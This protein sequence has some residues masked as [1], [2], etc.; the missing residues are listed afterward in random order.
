MTPQIAKSDS[1][2]T[3]DYHIETKVSQKTGKVSPTA[4]IT[5]YA[6]TK[7]R[8]ARIKT[9]QGFWQVF[10]EN[11]LDVSYIRNDL[12]RGLYVKY[13]YKER[14]A[15][16]ETGVLDVQLYWINKKEEEKILKTLRY[17]IKPAA[18]AKD[19]LYQ[20][21]AQECLQCVA[22]AYNQA[23]ATEITVDN[24]TSFLNY[25]SMVQGG[26]SANDTDK[27]RIL[28][29]VENNTDFG[30]P[31]NQNIEVYNFG[32]GNPL[33]IL[34]SVTIAKKLTSLYEGNNY[35]FCHSGSKHVD[36]Y[37]ESWKKARDQILNNKQLFSGIGARE[38]DRNKWNPADIFA[39]KSSM[40][41]TTYDFPNITKTYSTSKELSVSDIRKTIQKQGQTKSA[42]INLAQKIAKKA[43]SAS[44]V[45][46]MPSLNLF[47]YNLAEKTKK[48]YPIS[49]K[50][51]ERS[52]NLQR[53]NP[54]IG[55]PIKMKATLQKVDWAN[56]SKKGEGATN[57]IEV[58]F[59]VKVGNGKPKNYY[60]NARQ[61]NANQDIKF[62]IEM[63]GGL[64]FH[65]KAGLKIGELIIN[66]TDSTMKPE[67]VKLRKG[68]K[69]TYTYFNSSTDLFS[70]VSDIQQSYRN[71]DSGRPGL[72]EYAS[73]LSNGKVTQFPP[74][75]TGY[76]SKIQA[77]EFGYIMESRN[78]NGITSRILYSL[79]SYAGSKGLV[80]FDGK[81]YKNFYAASFHVKVL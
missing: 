34:S 49:L 12:V 16:F 76:I 19:S 59:D 53:I 38:L 2:L 77:S 61:F 65:G 33:W 3:G 25:V 66:K 46:D 40:K 80:I 22:C 5:L 70:S 36:W 47:L 14:A 39:M 54:G 62:Q 58:H 68:I 29:E 17:G 63:R 6:T 71:S 24:F 81:D 37:W 60:I 28:R 57:K 23:I 64:A 72:E 18:N 20:V 69:D 51:V 21:T 50:K 4:V 1:I 74:S 75:S 78:S 26:A 41:S 45:D 10:E 9:V 35:F 55:I 8:F 42:T 48:L 32:I 73:I 79:Y 52:C 15:G 43:D 13:D 31:E 30:I 67:M 11:I 56:I 27:N 7:D 44:T